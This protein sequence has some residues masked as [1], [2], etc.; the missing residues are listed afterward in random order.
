MDQRE[1]GSGSPVLPSPGHNTLRKPPTNTTSPG[2]SR[3]GSIG[4]VIT[5]HSTSLPRTPPPETAPVLVPNTRRSS[6]VATSV[7]AHVTLPVIIAQQKT[8]PQPLPVVSQQSAS[9]EEPLEPSDPRPLQPYFWQKWL[10]EVLTGPTARFWAFYDL[11]IRTIDIFHILA[12]PAMFAYC[13]DIGLRLVPIYIACDVVLCI[14]LIVDP[15]RPFKDPF[16]QL[17]AKAKEKRK[18]HWMLWTTKFERLS[19][20][21]LDWILLAFGEIANSLYCANPVLI[22]EGNMLQ[23][24]VQAADF[25]YD[26]IRYGYVSA[27]IP[28]TL[29]LYTTARIIRL[30]H[31]PR[32]LRWLIKFRVPRVA[33]P[34]SRM[35]KN[36]LFTVIFSHIDSC[37]FWTL[38]VNTFTEISYQYFEI[39]CSIFGN[40]SS[41]VRALDSQAGHDKAVKA[42]SY[43]KMLLH[44]YMKDYKFPPDLQTKVLQQE[45]FDWAHKKGVNTDELFKQLPQSVLEQVNYHLYY[46]LI[47]SVPIFKEHADEVIKRALCQKISFINITPNFYICKAGDRGTEMYLCVTFSLCKL[48]KS[49]NLTKNY[50]LRMGEVDVLSPK[51][52]KVF[53]T[54]GPGA[55]F[56][57]VALFSSSLRTAT[58][59]SRGEVQLCVLKKKEFDEILTQHSSLVDAFKVQIDKRYAADLARDEALIEEENRRLHPAQA[60]VTASNSLGLHRLKVAISGRISRSLRGSTDRSHGSGLSSRYS[61]FVGTPSDG[62]RRFTV[63]RGGSAEGP[64]AR[65]LLS[66]ASASAA[67]AAAGSLRASIVAVESEALQMVSCVEVQESGLVVIGK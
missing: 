50:S 26:M 17:I 41:I 27:N 48:R 21:P 44:Q 16:G 28:W 8:E 62:R 58:V 55:F 1:P 52:D 61:V 35:A 32:T 40:M 45:E 33:D 6:V 66:S 65:G 25:P 12:I 59:K 47:A 43:H 7:A 13:C 4:S 19:M 67:G 23:S 56:G 15:L 20:L 2:T 24:P 36:L 34:I 46:S 38:S 3:R 60:N 42:R 18:A 39:L 49:I 30:L 22:G 63:S 5:A 9:L 10:Q 57:E 11:L 37:I 54:L 53:V 64:T 31:T 29:R 51:E 14:S